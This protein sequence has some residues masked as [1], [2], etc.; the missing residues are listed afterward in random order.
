[1]GSFDIFF[2]KDQYMDHVWSHAIGMVITNSLNNLILPKTVPCSGCFIAL[3]CTHSDLLKGGK[4]LVSFVEY[5]RQQRISCLGVYAERGYAYKWRPLSMC[6]VNMTLYV[7]SLD[8]SSS[9]NLKKYN[10]VAAMIFICLYANSF[11]K[12]MRGPAWSWKE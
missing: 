6:R 7:G 10:R 5:A 1:M 9:L 8:S 11:P 3:V 2:L 4:T 12:Q